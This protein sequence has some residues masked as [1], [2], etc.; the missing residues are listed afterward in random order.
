MIFCRMISFRYPLNVT[1]S[2]FHRRRSEQHAF[3]SHHVCANV[4]SFTV[5][6]SPKHIPY[7]G[8]IIANA[9]LWSAWNYRFSDQ[10]SFILPPSRNLH[11]YI[12]IWF[13]IHMVGNSSNIGLIDSIWRKYS[14]SLF[15][16]NSKTKSLLKAAETK[17]EGFH[18]KNC[19]YSTTYSWQ[20]LRL[21]LII[22][23]QKKRRYIHLLRRN[24]FDAS[25]FPLLFSIKYQQ[26]ASTIAL[27]VLMEIHTDTSLWE[28]CLPEH[29]IGAESPKRIID[30]NIIVRDRP[31]PENTMRP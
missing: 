29:R 16:R 18:W 31:E 15:L 12:G 2:V 25:F 17:I 21:L 20:S 19:W 27:L 9:F 5:G 26:M 28:V 6:S 22:A 3:L 10:Y 4:R 7:F 23:Y 24:L 8:V 30:I 14:S 13:A 1:K 11:F